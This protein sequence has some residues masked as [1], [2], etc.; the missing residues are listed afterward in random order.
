MLLTGRTGQ[1]EKSPIRVA[2]VMK[3]REASSR[4]R[5]SSGRRSV[6]RGATFDGVERLVEDKRDKFELRESPDLSEG[7]EVGES[8]NPY[9]PRGA[10]GQE[11]RSMM[12]SRIV[13]R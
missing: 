13:M 7:V 10:D 3:M 6:E 8:E 1:E 2:D 9:L 4:L 11:S 12:P 5:K